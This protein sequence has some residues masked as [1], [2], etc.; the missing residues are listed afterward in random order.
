M[1]SFIRDLGLGPSTED[2]SSEE[3]VEAMAT[4]K[5]RGKRKTKK[6]KQVS[7]SKEDDEV[8]KLYDLDNYDSEEEEGE[9]MVR[10]LYARVVKREGMLYYWS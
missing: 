8:D 7:E 1:C 9:S 5:G 4:E 6:T 10:L 3:K 2:A